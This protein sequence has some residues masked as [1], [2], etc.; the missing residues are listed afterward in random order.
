MRTI[1]N[2][3]FVPKILADKRENDDKNTSFYACLRYTIISEE[4][5]AML[6]DML[7]LFDVQY[8]TTGSKN[9]KS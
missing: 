1:I 9:D 4:A 5:I 2:A 3:Y 6:S 8:N 7:I